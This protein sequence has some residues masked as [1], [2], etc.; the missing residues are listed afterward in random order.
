MS[1]NSFKIVLIIKLH[2]SSISAIL[3]ELLLSNSINLSLQNKKVPSSKVASTICVFV[4]FQGV[5]FWVEW[6][7]F[8]RETAQSCLQLI[9]QHSDIR[10]RGK[11]CSNGLYTPHSCKMEPQSSL[12]H[13]NI[14]DCSSRCTHIS[15]LMTAAEG[16]NFQICA[17]RIKKNLKGSLVRIMVL[18][19]QLQKL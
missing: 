7:R 14:A 18:L 8:R 15:N 16:N 11:P 12:K 5:V 4:R 6:V 1:A 9:I 10:K 3:Q 19:L 2:S 17:Y 13:F